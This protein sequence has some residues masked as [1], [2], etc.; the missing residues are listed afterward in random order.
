MNTRESLDR[1]PLEEMAKR[2]GEAGAGLVAAAHAVA[3]KNS[4][5]QQEAYNRRVADSHR[6]GL[7]TMQ[8]GDE[9]IPREDSAV[10]GDIIVTGD[11]YGNEAVEALKGRHAAPAPAPPPPAPPPPI[12]PPKSGLSKAAKVATAL[13]AALLVGTG[14]TGVGVPLAAWLGAFDKA[15]PPAVESEWEDTDTLPGVVIERPTTNNEP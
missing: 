7:A 10:G 5:A 9:L 14:A 3:L 12:E 1:G 6:A 2:A 15:T 13:G 8:S 4:V 11:L